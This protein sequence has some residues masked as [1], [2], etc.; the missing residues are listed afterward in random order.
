MAV[1]AAPALLQVIVGDN[2]IRAFCRRVWP[3]PRDP[4]GRSRPG[5]PS[6]G[7][8]RWSLPAPARRRRYDDEPPRRLIGGDAQP[9]RADRATARAATCGTETESANHSPP[10]TQAPTGWSRTA[11][12]ARRWQGRAPAPPCSAPGCDLVELV[13]DVR[14]WSVGDANAG[15]ADSMRSVSPRPAADHDAASRGIAHGVGEQ[16]EQDPLQQHGSVRTHALLGTTRSRRPLSRAAREHGASGRE[17]AD[18]KVGDAGLHPRRHRAA[19]CP[20][21]R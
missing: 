7:I 8:A 15:V 1:D 18:R 4:T 6:P 2:E 21:A 3:A 14:C 5:I 16:I 12:S 11:Q 13:E 10:S 9:R 17:A 20:A 19:R